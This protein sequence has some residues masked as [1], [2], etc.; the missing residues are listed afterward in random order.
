MKIIYEDAHIVVVSKPKNILSQPDEKGT[1][2]LLDALSQKIGLPLGLVHR[3]DRPVGGL[4]VFS[5]TPQALKQ[6]NAQ[7]QEKNIQKKYL[8]VVCGHAEEEAHLLHYIKKQSTVNRAKVLDEEKPRTKKALLHYTLLEK[9]LLPKG[10]LCLLSVSL[11]TGRF[12]QIRA[13]LAHVN[14][15]I[16]GDRKYHLDFV[17][18]SGPYCLGLWSYQ[19]SFIHPKTQKPLYFMEMPPSTNPWSFFHIEKAPIKERI[20]L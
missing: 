8:A 11:E 1:E 7:M 9:Q 6:L 16:W 15:P 5:K 18:Q 2:N 13:Q 17:K 14:L 3:L 12:H 4:M 10:P 20:S 19:L